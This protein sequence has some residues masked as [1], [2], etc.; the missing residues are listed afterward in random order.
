MATPSCPK[1]SYTLFETTI[2]SPRKS[3]YKLQFIH[4]ASC[5]C[6]VGTQEYYNI[7]AVLQTFAKKLGVS[8]GLR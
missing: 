2:V 8:L 7:G 5:G 4:C 1:C 3:N 6:V